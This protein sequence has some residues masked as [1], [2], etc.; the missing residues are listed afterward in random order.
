MTLKL[1]FKGGLETGE[2]EGAGS[3]GKYSLGSRKNTDNST[4]HQI[5]C[6]LK[7]YTERGG[8]SMLRELRTDEQN[9]GKCWSQIAKGLESQVGSFG[10]CSVERLPAEASRY[11]AQE[12]RHT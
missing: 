1:N 5:W 3:V 7:W 11:S 12:V 2:R 9:V 10:V 4:D 6:V 8:N